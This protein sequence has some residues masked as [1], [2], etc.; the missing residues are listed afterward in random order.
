MNLAS[1]W[2]HPAAESARICH[3]QWTPDAGLLEAVS[4]DDASLAELIDVFKT[5]TEAR[6]LRIRAALDAADLARVR[7]EA[8]AIAGSARQ[9]GADALGEVCEQLELATAFTPLPYF[10]GLVL[11]LQ[12]LFDEVARAMH[13]YQSFRG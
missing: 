2:N 11:R 1:A 6:L 9:I 8:H 5:D 4:G 7:S 12:E 3:A 10:S 13:S